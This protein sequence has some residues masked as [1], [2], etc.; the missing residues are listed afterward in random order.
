MKGLWDIHC[1]HC[2]RLI[3]TFLI[4]PARGEMPCSICGALNRYDA[5]KPE[6]QVF[7]LPPGHTCEPS[8]CT[9]AS[10][11]PVGNLASQE[12]HPNRES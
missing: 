12:T 1:A 11:K 3:L 6:V 2:G 7:E 5:T 9:P 8:K 4:F 10:S